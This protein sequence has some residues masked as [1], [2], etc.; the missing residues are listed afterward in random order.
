MKL[1]QF[2]GRIEQ[3]PLF[4]VTE[5][6]RGVDPVQLEAR[7]IDQERIGVGVRV[8][9]GELARLVH[10]DLAE[11]FGWRIGAGDLPGRDPF[12]AGT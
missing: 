6:D 8:L 10:R 12:A 4:D 9:K 1:V 11:V 2:L 3:P 5:L 7:A